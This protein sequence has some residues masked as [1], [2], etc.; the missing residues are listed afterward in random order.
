MMIKAFEARCGNIML[1]L[2]WNVLALRLVLPGALFAMFLIIDT[3]GLSFIV[4]M[5]F[6]SVTVLPIRR[7]SPVFALVIARHTGWN[8]TREAYS[9]VQRQSRMRN[10]GVYAIEMPL[11]RPHRWN[12][13]EISGEKDKNCYAIFH[14]NE[15]MS[16]S[17]PRQARK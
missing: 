4:I 13:D 11:A 7:T 15:F 6:V 14:I 17:F 9:G 12:T 3:V 16:I 5:P 8:G 2:T 1:K 10:C